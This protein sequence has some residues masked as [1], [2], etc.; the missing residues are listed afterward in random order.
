MARRRNPSD[1]M[2]AALLE[3]RVIV[4]C[5]SGGVGKTTTAAALGLQAAIKG[6]RVLVCTIDPSRRLATSLGL[7]QLSA[8]PRTLDL[9]RFADSSLVPQRD[10]VRAELARLEAVSHERWTLF[11]AFVPTRENPAGIFDRATIDAAIERS[12]AA[13][14]R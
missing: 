7:S 6:R 8:K 12:L 2:E 10:S 14:R 11:R 9:R 3:R 1:A 13:E 4:V 5:G